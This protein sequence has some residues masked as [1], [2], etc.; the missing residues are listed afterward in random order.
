MGSF[1]LPTDFHDRL[2]CDNAI[3]PSTMR[4]PEFRSPVAMSNHQQLS[5]GRAKQDFITDQVVAMVLFY[6]QAALGIALGLSTS[7]TPVIYRI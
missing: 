1:T 3:K 2:R 7:T 6:P 4:C 5:M